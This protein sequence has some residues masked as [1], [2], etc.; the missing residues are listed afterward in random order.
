MAK[1]A[2]KTVKK[3][4]TAKGNSDKNWRKPTKRDV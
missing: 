3:V 4:S 1:T 2:T